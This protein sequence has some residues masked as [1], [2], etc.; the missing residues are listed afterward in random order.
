MLQAFAKIFMRLPRSILNS[1][2]S[3]K[4]IAIYSKILLIQESN[5]NKVCGKYASENV[6]VDIRLFVTLEKICD[7]FYVFSFYNLHSTINQTNNL[8]M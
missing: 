6:S 7:L 3:H 2:H 4:Y 5:V 8:S 1:H